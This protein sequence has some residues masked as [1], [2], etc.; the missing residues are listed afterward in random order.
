MARLVYIFGL[1]TPRTRRVSLTYLLPD[2]EAFTI[3]VSYLS[4]IIGVLF[5]LGVELTSQLKEHVAL[6]EKWKQEYDRL[7][8]EVFLCIALI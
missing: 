7:E 8:K 1:T 4:F 5:D 6:E 2:W 3:E